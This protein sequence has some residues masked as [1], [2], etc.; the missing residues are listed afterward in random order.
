MANWTREKKRRHYKRKVE[1]EKERE[2]IEKE[3]NNRNE[4]NSHERLVKIAP[5][6]FLPVIKVCLWPHE[7]H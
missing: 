5:I 4:W 2:M 7:I 1:R 6:A 3:K